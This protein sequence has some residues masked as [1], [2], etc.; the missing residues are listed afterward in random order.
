MCQVSEL[1]Q[2]AVETACKK[3]RAKEMELRNRLV[4]LEEHREREKFLRAQALTGHQTYN[5]GAFQLLEEQ[6]QAANDVREYSRLAALFLERLK[7]ERDVAQEIVKGDVELLPKVPIASVDLQEL[8]Q[9]VQ[10]L[11]CVSDSD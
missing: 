9:K 10:A 4:S 6:L 5:D 1:V 7:L 11:C 8:S 3:H 2:A